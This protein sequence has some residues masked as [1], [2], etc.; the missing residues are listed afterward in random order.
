M[1]PVESFLNFVEDR[2]GKRT[3]VATAGVI[4]LVILLVTA[5]VLIPL[6]SISAGGR[7][8]WLMAREEYAE[9]ARLTRWMWSATVKGFG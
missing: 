7:E 2:L 3:A 5:I 9:V 6:V 1:K 4:G 8:A